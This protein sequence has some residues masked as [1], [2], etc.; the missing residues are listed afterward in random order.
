MADDPRA[1]E[2]QVEAGEVPPEAGEGD[3]GIEPG[4]AGRRR[5]GFRM[6][7]TLGRLLSMVVIAGGWS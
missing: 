5:R 6:P 4:T 7:N 2:G 1:E 3:L